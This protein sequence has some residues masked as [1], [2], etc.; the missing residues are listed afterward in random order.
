MPLVSPLAAALR[1]ASRSIEAHG[2]GVRGLKRMLLRTARLVRALGIRGLLKRMNAA[3]KAPLLLPTDSDVFPEPVAST[4]LELRV[5]VMVHMFYDDLVA[6]FA[7]YLARIPVPFALMVSVI[8]ARAEEKA[9]TYFSVL[10]HVQSLHIRI[11]ENR[12][13]DIAPLLVTFREEILAL[14]V[15][16]HI[17]TKKSL[18][19]G[20]E[21]TAWRRHLLD[22]LLGDANRVGRHLGLLQADPKIGILYPETFRGVPVWGHTWLSN[23]EVCR[24]LGSRLGIAIEANRYI[25]FPAG[26]MFWARVPALRPLLKLGLRIEDF[27]T[28]RGQTDGEIQHAIERLLVAVV[29]QKGGIAAIISHDGSLVSE[30]LRNWPNG[31]D[32]PVATRLRV[33]AIEAEQISSDVFDTMVL[34][35]FLTPHGAR[36]HLAHRARKELG[37]QDFVDLRGR[38]EAKARALAGRDPTLDAIYSSMSSLPGASSLPLDALK[39]LELALEGRQLRARREVVN[40]LASLHKKRPLLALSDIYFDTQTLKALLPAEVTSIVERWQVSCESGIRKDNDVLW[41]TM[42]EAH[43]IPPERWLHIGDNEQADIQLPQR[44]RLATPVHVPRPA[45]LLDLHPQLRPLR[46]PRF[47]QA[48]WADQLWLGLVANHVAEA[49]DRDPAAWLP[50]PVLSAYQAGYMVLGPLLLDYLAWLTRTAATR[51]TNDL[52]FLSREGHLL[53]Q[54]FT[55]LQRCS[56]SLVHLRGHYLPTSRRA[57]GTAS[58]R[59]AEDLPRLFAGNFGGKFRDLLRTRLGESATMAVESSIGSTALNAD[60]FL[61]E[62]RQTV[63][64]RIAPA[65]KQLL[66]VAGRERD[67]YQ[68]YWLLTLG[69]RAAIVSDLG[70]SGSTQASLARMMDRPLDGG[71]FALSARATDGLDGQWAAARYHDGR[72][73]SPDADST[74]LRYDLLL[75]TLLTAPHPQF[76]HFSGSDGHIEEHYLAPELG[77]SQWAL[78]EQVHLGALAFMDD[79]CAAAGED[80]VEIE[81]DKSLVQRPLECL[82]T[83]RWT[84]PWLSELSVVDA[85]TGRGTVLAR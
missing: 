29:R 51:S 32:T 36:A 45:S 67:A 24:E 43:A 15:V 21:Q 2:G 7:D 8:D 20:S 80:A 23:F 33:A 81:S 44:H 28:E 62:M 30:G 48:S 1:A 64:E 11:I 65:M 18:Y 82:G 83:E 6:E 27:P 78:I 16:G 35:P 42:P 73:S 9:N 53:S 14:D 17:H 52:L 19:A 60:V 55:R 37:V 77:K 75:E 70:Y 39:R 54:A 4:E 61:P 5:G 46:P 69:N 79:A 58:L 68:A 40:A 49:F 34:R 22:T 59:S 25:D 13:R 85:F 50:K 76:S 57:S 47:D 26:S 12:G 3:G 41:S 66:S 71:Y 38:A 72:V 74:I 63:L 84:A 31:L 10:P 56:P